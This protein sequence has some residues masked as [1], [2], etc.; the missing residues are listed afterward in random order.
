MQEGAGTAGGLLWAVTPG[1]GAASQSLAALQFPSCDGNPLRR[2]GF[3]LF[4]CSTFAGSLLRTRITGGES[5]SLQAASIIFS[6]L[7]LLGPQRESK[8]H[9]TPWSDFVSLF[10][11]FTGKHCSPQTG[12]LPHRAPAAS[13]TRENHS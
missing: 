5:K 7:G 10:H 3:S 4:Q 11:H 6:W 1:W 9:S 8:S 12:F 2:R 13:Q